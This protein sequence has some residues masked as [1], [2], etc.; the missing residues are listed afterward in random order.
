L[1]ILLAT[2]P[3]MLP[4]N[5]DWTPLTTPLLYLLL[6]GALACALFYAYLLHWQP[7]WPN[8]AWYKAYQAEKRLQGQL[9]A[10]Q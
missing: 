4:V 7:S 5:D 3:G 8:P 6:A 9:G 1:A 2:T 10:K